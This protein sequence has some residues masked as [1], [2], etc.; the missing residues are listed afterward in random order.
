[1]KE[2]GRKLNMA[3]CTGIHACKG[4]H[5]DKTQYECKICKIQERIHRNAKLKGTDTYE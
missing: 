4:Q 2:K 3:C 5:Y 1:M